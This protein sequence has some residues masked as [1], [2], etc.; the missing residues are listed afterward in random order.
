[1]RAGTVR[2]VVCEGWDSGME[3]KHQCHCSIMLFPHIRTC[4]I[5]SALQSLIIKSF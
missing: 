5:A 3:I 4:Y 1:M 2:R